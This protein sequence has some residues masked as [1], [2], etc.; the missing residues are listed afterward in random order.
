MENDEENDRE[1]S[2]CGGER[3]VLGALGGRTHFRCRNC[4]MQSSEGY[5]HPVPLTPV[6]AVKLATSKK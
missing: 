2:V 3:Q 6:P 5:P 1:C 4:G